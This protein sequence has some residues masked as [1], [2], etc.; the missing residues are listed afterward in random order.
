MAVSLEV[1]KKEKYVPVRLETNYVT[2]EKSQL[3]LMAIK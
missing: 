1:S 2:K 3:S